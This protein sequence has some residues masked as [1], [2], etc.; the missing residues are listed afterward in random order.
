MSSPRSDRVSFSRRGRLMLM[1]ST[2]ASSMVSI[3]SR[4]STMNV[5]TRAPASC[6]RSTSAAAPRRSGFSE[7]APAATPAGLTSQ[8]PLRN[9]MSKENK[10]SALTATAMSSRA[11]DNPAGHPM[12]KSAP[13]RDRARRPQRR[14]T[15]L[16]QT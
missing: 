4:S 14:V 6:A 11:F 15:R 8:Q 3:R 16:P 10:T 1:A 12:I 2:P 9:P 13:G 7:M 5:L